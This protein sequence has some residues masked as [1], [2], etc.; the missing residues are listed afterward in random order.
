MA[1]KLAQLEKKGG[2]EDFD[3]S[4]V[5]DALYNNNNLGNSATATLAVTKKPKMIV[6]CFINNTI[7]NS[8]L[9]GIINVEKNT[10]YRYGLWSGSNQ[11]AVWSNFNNYITAITDTSV[12]IKN[13]YG[14]S[15]NVRV[16]AYY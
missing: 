11:N 6:A 1:E 12:S 16:G 4:K 14:E 8:F 15:C 9:V 13:S 5:P 7:P 2:G 3:F 10:A